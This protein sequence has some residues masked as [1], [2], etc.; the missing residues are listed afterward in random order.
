MLSALIPTERSY[1]AMPLVRQLE[2]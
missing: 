2:H 1:P